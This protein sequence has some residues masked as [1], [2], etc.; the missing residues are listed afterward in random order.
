ME[1]VASRLGESDPCRLV[2]Q[3]KQ[4]RGYSGVIKACLVP[5]LCLGTHL[6]KLCFPS[7]LR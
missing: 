7:S 5:K 3:V 6:W 4:F 2:R 1:I